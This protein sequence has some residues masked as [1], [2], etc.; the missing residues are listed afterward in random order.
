MTRSHAGTAVPFACLYGEKYHGVL[1]EVS[2]R[3]TPIIRTPN[4]LSGWPLVFLSLWDTRKTDR[5]H[6]LEE[7][8]HARVALEDWRKQTRPV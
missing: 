1:E 8:M 3:G 2:P 6:G 4:H 5:M 7:A